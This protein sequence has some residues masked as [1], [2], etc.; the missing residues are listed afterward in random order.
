MRKPSNIIDCNVNNTTAKTWTSSNSCK[1]MKLISLLNADLKILMEVLAKRLQEIILQVIHRD[2]NGFI[3]GRQG[4]YNVRK[5]LNIIQG[6]DETTDI[7]LSCLW[8]PKRHFIRW[9]G[10]I[11]SMSWNDLDMGIT[12]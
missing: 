8:M 5:V 11:Y 4:F 2:Q 7:G 10:L 9:S 12:Y 1:N 3:L 6:L